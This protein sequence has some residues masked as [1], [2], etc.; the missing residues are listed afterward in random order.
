MSQPTS[1][2]KNDNLSVTDTDKGFVNAVLENAS[3]LVVVLDHQGRIRRFNRACETLSGYRLDEVEGKFP[4]DTVLPPEDAETIGK[5]AFEALANNPDQLSGQYSNYWLAKDGERN[6]IDWYNTVQ[7]DADGKMELMVSIGVDVTGK[8]SVEEALKR[9]EE[10]Y[11]RAEAIAHIGSWDWDILAG[12]LRWT[13]EIFR[14]FGQTPQSFGATYDAFLEAIHPDDRDKVIEAVNASVADAAVPYSIEHRVIR[15]DGEVR[16][17]HERGEVYWD[18]DGNPVRMIGTVHDVTKQKQAEHELLRHREQLEELVQERTAELAEREQQLRRAQEIANLGHWTANVQT[19]ELVWSD[20]IYRIFGR[21]PQSFSPNQT[22]FYQTVHPQDV[23]MIKRSQDEAFSLGQI[24]RVDHRIVLPDG[25]VRWV[26]E[27][28]VTEVDSNG[29]PLRMTGT[30]QDITERKQAETE[31]FNAKEAAE[32]A[33][34]AKGEF[35]SRMSHELRTPMNAILGFAQVL[36]MESLV[37][38][39]REYVGEITQASNHLLELINELL[40]LSKIEAG[41]MAVVTR[42]VVALET[43]RQ[44]VAIVRS[45]INEKQIDLVIDCRSDFVILVDATRF[46]QVLVNLLTNAVKYN[47]AGGSVNIQCLEQDNRQLRILISDTGRGIPKSEM[48]KLFVP[49]ERLGAEN[50]GI[51]GTGIGLVLAR[52]LTEMMGGSLGLE[53]TEGKGLT[54]WV[55][56]P[57]AEIEPHS[58]AS[59]A[60]SMSSDKKTDCTVLYVED[61][62]ANLRV[63]QAMFR[64]H[65]EMKLIAA[66]TGEHGLELAN[67]Y[68][69]DVIL[70][71]IQLPDMNGYDVLKKLQK[72]HDTR[73]IPVVALSADAMPIDIEHGIEAGFREY[74]TKP[75]KSDH[76]ISVLSGLIVEGISS[77]IV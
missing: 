68:L 35:L 34:N 8:R 52:Q 18:N 22:R 75:V 38:F 61:N 63:V 70:L 29:N 19:G 58:V 44:A 50:S 30:V 54:V 10:T 20:Q 59:D 67:K 48:P 62:A 5:Q 60:V 77:A 9:S 37:G 17:V 71:D 66:S 49:F 46:K 26:H 24:F 4:W 14:I 47:R 16:I 27:E 41:K 74:L 76:L 15:P 31:L 7:L 1:P 55:D 33:N 39:Q 51:D 21:E 28:A 3:T 53:S 45:E 23:E 13:D 36:E 65:P 43:I 40:D 72:T 6:R 73:H 2:A 69:P 32:R 57:V 56:F 25:E 64:H 42:P 12:D 11:S